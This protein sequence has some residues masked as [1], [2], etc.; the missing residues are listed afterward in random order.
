MAMSR[1]QAKIQRLGLEPL[2]PDVI[3]QVVC[4]HQLREEELP[5]TLAADDSIVFRLES[6]LQ[7]VNGIWLVQDC[8]EFTLDL[9]Q[10]LRDRGEIHGITLRHCSHFRITASEDDLLIPDTW[11]GKHLLLLDQCKVFAL[12]DV[13]VQG[14]RNPVVLNDCSRFRIGGL[15]VSHARGY[16]LTLLRCQTGMVHDSGFFA[17]L[18][19]GIN[20]VGQCRELHIR[21]CRITGSRGPYNWDAGINCM[22]CSQAVTL[23]HVPEESH[24]AL[25]LRDKLDTPHCVW[26][27]ACE[28][29]HCRAQGIYL[30]GGAQLL[31]ED[32]SIHDNNKEGI[33]FDWG[34][35]LSYLRC[36]QLVRNGE[37][38]EYDDQTCAIDFLPT[39]FRD[40]NGRHYC[41][42]PGVSIDNG[43]SNT[44]E[45]N[46]ISAN[47]GGG[48]KLVRSAFENIIQFNILGANLNKLS[49]ANGSSLAANPYHPSELKILNMGPGDQQEFKSESA[50]LDFLPPRG[51]RIRQNQTLAAS[52]LSSNALQC[53]NNEE[54]MRDN[55]LDM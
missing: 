24:E 27:E 48:I 14:S 4:Q 25:D 31:I 40:R 9:S 34:T 7:R 12:Q 13:H 41:Q 42:L 35:A 38:A 45:R 26:I 18:A 6:K 32:C 49:L 22:H 53:W 33:C 55:Q 5:S 50:L 29:S 52:A 30:E 28:I 51:N 8:H 1:A 37:R 11:D 16:G 3:R 47:Y 10:L 36:C 21:Q 39:Q 17:C 19:S 43:Y 54:A 46:L 23:Q 2:A 44:I 20:I 15:T